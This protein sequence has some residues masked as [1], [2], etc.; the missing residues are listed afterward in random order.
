MEIFYVLFALPCALLW[1]SMDSAVTG[2]ISEE[3][4]RAGKFAGSRGISG[5][6][7]GEYEP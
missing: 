5:R 1:G 6:R 4:W 2:I 7:S 3:P